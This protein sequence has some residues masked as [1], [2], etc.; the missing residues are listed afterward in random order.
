MGQSEESVLR[1][2]PEIGV[3]PVVSMDAVVAAGG[4]CGAAVRA[5]LKFQ[6]RLTD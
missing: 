5:P 2:P 1:W 6:R 4:G 3:S